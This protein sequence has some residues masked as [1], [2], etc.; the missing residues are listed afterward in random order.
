MERKFLLALVMAFASAST[1]WT[2]DPEDGPGRGVARI[3]LLNGDVSVKRGESGD[4]IAA[5]LN[6]PLVV[7]DRIFTGAA[8]RAE[9][10]FDWA[11]MIRLSSNA[12]IRLAELEYQRY[13]IQV[14]RGTVTFRVLR[15]QEADV[16][17]STPSVAVR[18][19]KRGMYRISVHDD[20]TSEITVRSGEA[21]IFTTRGSERLRSGRTM[22]AR[23]TASDPEFRVA[24]E[25]AEDDWDRWNTG[26][27]GDLER[28]RSYNYLSRDIYGAEDLD[29]HGRWVHVPS[30][31]HVWS[32][33][34]AFGWAP[35][36]YGRWAWVDWYG[37]TWISHDPWGWA[38]YHYGR[39]FYSSPYGWCWYPGR[40]SIRHYWS[41][42]LVAFVGFG[43]GVG[44]GFGFGRVGW[45]PLA[46]YERFNRWWGPRYYN[47]YRNRTYIDNSVTI[48]NNVNVRT[49]F[50]NGRVND[51]ITA[52]DR[53]GFSRG[54]VGRAVRG[55]D[56]EFSSARLVQGQLPVVPSRESL[57]VADRGATTVAESRTDRF[58]SRRGAAP[59]DKVPFEDQQRGVEQTAR[60][61]FGDDS[62]G[63][64]S[65]TAAGTPGG[66]RE[67]TSESRGWRRADEPARGADRGNAE[68]QRGL[69]ER[70][71]STERRGGGAEPGGGDW[72]RF[73]TPRTTEST[74]G[75]DG[76]RGDRLGRFGEPATVRS[77]DQQPAGSP[78]SAGSGAVQERNPAQDRNNATSRS[79]EDGWR[80]FSGRGSSD[81]SVASD[82]SSG[83][84]AGSSGR[85][86]REGWQ[87]DLNTGSESPGRDASR[88][89]T[90]RSSESP[91]IDSS[92]ENFSRGFP[93][94]ME[95]P[96]TERRTDRG[97]EVRISPPIVRDRGSFGGG[98]ST[99]SAPRMSS[100]RVEGGGGGS[101]GGGGM[102]GADS[103][104]GRGGGGGGGNSGGGGGGTRGGEGR[105]G[106]GR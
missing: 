103:G 70:N 97:G 54:R 38:P 6:A 19:I 55:D 89:E 96:R 25:I 16:E 18:P 32:P 15:D 62:R 49:S 79:S 92:R 99:R 4:F 9:L 81:R 100:P 14:A 52:I 101:R 63:G 2:Q 73:G 45:I 41:P 47:G 106:R 7:Q 57:R 105:G 87:R 10:Q 85:S 69:V 37:W 58:F 34:V 44:V 1:G 59:V 17:V 40:A 60:R 72:R 61:V 31:G 20:G 66:P 91:R 21:E 94:G 86:D 71:G 8:S 82:P 75:A 56:A 74:A 95:S 83:V 36:R 29:D 48:V 93:S 30:Y 104:G 84:G 33:R 76:T 24:D 42:A 67:A 65:V 35:Y 88:G 27:D 5:A 23:G 50:R 43:R 26:R 13:I 53:D 68:L 39:W 98:D 80:R 77:L 90:G 3:S 22:Y 12:E 11:N 64:G 78:Q 28:S 46:P 102:R 51:A